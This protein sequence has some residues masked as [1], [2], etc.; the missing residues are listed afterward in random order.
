M[1]AMISSVITT[2]IS[3]IYRR[4]CYINYL[5]KFKF[6]ANCKIT[7]SLANTKLTLTKPKLTQNP[8]VK[9]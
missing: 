7:I 1:V 6:Y 2:V 8:N 9:S 4:L 5:Q 3:V